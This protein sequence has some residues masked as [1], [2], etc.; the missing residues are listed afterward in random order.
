MAPPTTIANK[1]KGLIGQLKSVEGLQKEN[2]ALRAENTELRRSFDALE[3]LLGGAVRRGPGPPRGSGRKAGARRGPGRPSGASRKAGGARFR[4]SADAVD[5]MYKALTAAA[6]ADW[7]S[8]EEICKA[9]GLNPSKCVAAWKRAMEG[10]KAADGTVYKPIL[11][12]NGSRG[13][14]GRYRKI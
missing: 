8:K 6:P 5:K 1:V 7:K 13:L 9:A 11:K 14:A 4:T 12:S 10:A 2:A 3:R